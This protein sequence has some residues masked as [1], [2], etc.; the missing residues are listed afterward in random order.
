MIRMLRSQTL[1]AAIGMATVV[2]VMV[3]LG[4][5]TV[6]GATVNSWHRQGAVAIAPKQPAAPLTNPGEWMKWKVHHAFHISIESREPVDYWTVIFERE[7]DKMRDHVTMKPSDFRTF[8]RLMKAA[9]PKALQGK[10]YQVETGRMLESSVNRRIFYTRR[11][12]YKAPGSEALIQL[13]QSELAEMRCPHFSE[14]DPDAVRQAFVEAYN[15]GFPNRDQAGQPPKIST[16]WMREFEAGISKKY[17]H[18]G[19]RVTSHPEAYGLPM[20]VEVRSDAVYGKRVVVVINP[21]PDGQAFNCNVRK[22]DPPRGLALRPSANRPKSRTSRL[23][24]YFFLARK[25]KT[26][27]QEGVLCGGL[28]ENRTPASTMRMWRH[29][30]RP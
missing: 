11:P 16:A 4:K 28:R 18:V 15:K 5:P 8:M 3:I 25:Q 20:I 1:T 22:A 14:H 24:P 17:P 21:T 30:T 29:T 27:S 2:A 9:D 26:P 13:A 12:N 7:M 10:R 19:A 23:R 6:T